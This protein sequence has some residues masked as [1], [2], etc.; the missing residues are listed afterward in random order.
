MISTP[1]YLRLVGFASSA[2]GGLFFPL[3]PGDVEFAFGMHVFGS[4]FIAIAL[5]FLGALYL[6]GEGELDKDDDGP[7]SEGIYSW[8][9]ASLKMSDVAGSIT[10]AG[11]GMIVRGLSLSPHNYLGT[12]AIGFGLGLALGI[13]CAYAWPPRTN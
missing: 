4:M 11:C 12:L 5:G 10:A 1:A 7:M 6:D 8:S 9:A 2:A 13:W 3:R